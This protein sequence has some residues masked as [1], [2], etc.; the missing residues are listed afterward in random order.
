MALQ[1]RRGNY[2]RRRRHGNNGER[3]DRM[4]G[5]AMTLMLGII[6]F[7]GFFVIQNQ[8]TMSINTETVWSHY[9]PIRPSPQKDIAKFEGAHHLRNGTK[10]VFVLHAGPP[11]TGT[12]TLQCSLPVLKLEED[13]FLYIGKVT[14]CPFSR[15]KRANY[16]NTKSLATCMNK[17]SGRNNTWLEQQCKEY[18][19]MKEILDFSLENDF[20]VIYSSEGF[21]DGFELS[22]AFKSL[23]SGFEVKV[24]IVYRRY[25]QWLP[26]RYNSL[27]KPDSN[28]HK[29]RTLEKWPKDGGQTIATFTKAYDSTFTERE[30]KIDL[31]SADTWNV[32]DLYKN[33]YPDISVLR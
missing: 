10:P 2:E 29:R 25:Y 22:D 27:S 14:D 18:R 12:T 8:I 4:C 15:K 11:K 16:V 17:Y 7:L 5:Y 26:S 20:D 13:G 1:S 21:F 30:R 6:L 28:R 19:K 3:S 33:H 23:V 24:M 31:F 32:F 9:D